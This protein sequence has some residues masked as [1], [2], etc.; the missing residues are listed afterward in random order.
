MQDTLLI[1][2]IERA[3]DIRDPKRERFA[4]RRA[5]TLYLAKAIAELLVDH[6]RVI[7]FMKDVGGRVHVQ[8]LPIGQIDRHLGD[9]SE[10]GGDLRI[11]IGTLPIVAIATRD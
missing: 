1:Q 8:L 5:H 7:D 2:S 4:I 6:N 9:R 3:A 10:R 11:R